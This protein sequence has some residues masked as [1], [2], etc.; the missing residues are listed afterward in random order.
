MTTGEV[1]TVVGL[2]LLAAGVGEGVIEFIVSPLLNLFKCTKDIPE[3][4][5][6]RTMILNSAS[7]LLGVLISLNFGIGVFVLL[8]GVDR[9]THLDQILTGILVGRGS[10]YIHS[11]V[12]KFILNKPVPEPNMVYGSYDYTCKR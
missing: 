7:A 1:F 11:L 8:G 10:N 9:F 6:L 12:E 2:V 3:N 5:P 4:L